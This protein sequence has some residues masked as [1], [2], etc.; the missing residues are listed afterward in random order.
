MRKHH[1]VIAACTFL[2]CLISVYYGIRIYNANENHLLT[3]LN[4]FDKLI[5]D[6]ISD[7]PYLSFSAAM[8]T[9]PILLIIFVFELIILFKVNQRKVKNITFGLML[10]TLIIL[11]FDLMILNQ[12]DYFDFSK[13]GFIWIC[14][15]LIILAGNIFSYALRRNEQTI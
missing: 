3:E 1:L 13:W 2:L 5:Y 7:V 9:L 15:G 6:D 8:I 11:A 12:P 14:L 4:E 10:F